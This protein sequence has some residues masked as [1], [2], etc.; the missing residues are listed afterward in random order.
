[1]ARSVLTH[2]WHV[3]CMPA[4]AGKDLVTLLV[5][6]LGFA[7]A[8]G[9]LLYHWLANTLQYQA[10][11][12]LGVACVYS[13][14]MFLLS[15]LCHPLR[16]VLTMT[17]P[18][19]CTKQGRKLLITASIIILVL[20]VV[21]NITVNVGA[22][23]SLLKCTAEAFAKTLLNSTES[24]NAAKRDLV[25][26]AITTKLGIAEKLTKFD[27]STN[28]D[29]SEV[30]DRLVGVLG[31]IK[32]RVTHARHLFHW[33]KLLSN[34]IFAGLFVALLTLE[35]SL[36]LKSYLTQLHFDNDHVSKDLQKSMGEKKQGKDRTSPFS[37]RCNVT[38]QECTSSFVTLTFVTLHF[39]AIAL[40]VVLD[41]V[42]YHVVQAIL[43]LLLDFPATSATLSVEYKVIQ[44]KNVRQ[45]C[46]VTSVETF[47][48]FFFVF[49][50]P[51][52]VVL[53]HFL[54]RLQ[55]LQQE[56]AHRL[57]P[58]LHLDLQP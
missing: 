33:C 31:Q 54:H 2:T 16:C 18:T 38:G 8:T 52:L 27:R 19:V 57:S 11:S 12:S 40:I 45:L 46:P 22:A 42:V 56:G 24:L 17:L 23:G 30:K 58:R 29:V 37:K 28:V 36:Y 25:R 50:L 9:G 53:F 15:F 55:R 10:Q 35:S 20:N 34:R 39:M 43:P 1:M 3:Y 32:E 7:V 41:H 5:L 14:L 44:R 49:S 48:T 21:P 51:G 47:S 6:C 13:A 4:P 26:E